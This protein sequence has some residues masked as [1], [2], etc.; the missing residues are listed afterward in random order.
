[1]PF[2]TLPPS[3][4]G[5]ISS[6]RY[7]DRNDEPDVAHHRQDQVGR[8]H[9]L[10]VGAMV[11]LSFDDTRYGSHYGE[12]EML[13]QPTGHLFVRWPHL[14]GQVGGEDMLFSGSVY[15]ASFRQGCSMLSVGPT[16][17]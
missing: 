8:S 17:C 6:C 10:L 5:I 2:V 1:M 13:L 15:A 16:T 14:A 11:I 3:F 7:V 12:I 9:N 4:V